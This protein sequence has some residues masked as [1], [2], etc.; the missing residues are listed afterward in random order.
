MKKL[1]Y[2]VGTTLLVAA[3][4]TP[5]PAPAPA[6]A[7]PVLRPYGTLAQMMQAIPFHNSN[8]IFDTQV[9]DP[10]AAAKEK[11]KGGSDQAASA[12]YAGVYGGW[13]AVENAAIALSETANLLTIPRMCSNGVPAPVEREDF[14]KFTQGLADA[15]DV[16]LKAAQSKNLDA[17][18]DAAGVVTEACDACHAVYRNTPNEPKDR[19]LP[20]AGK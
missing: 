12:L 2:V 5:A 18:V 8:I 16:A 7:A 14:K 10:G 4:S 1:C 20:P 9:N 13:T 15:G 3:C 17:M 6:P 11:S 19:C